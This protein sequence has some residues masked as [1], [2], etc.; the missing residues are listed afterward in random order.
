MK[1]NKMF[2][3]SVALALALFGV[4]FM[5]GKAFA[6]V[7]HGVDVALTVP[8]MCSL[9]ITNDDLS[10][11]IVPG[12]NYTIGTSNLKALC[13]DASGFAIYTVGYTG[14]TYGD[15]NLRITES[16]RSEYIPSSTTA[17]SKWNM[18]VANN[19]SVSGNYTATISDGTNG[20]ENFTT[21]HIVPTTYKMIASRTAS[22][23]QT[24]G[25][26]INTTFAVNVSYAQRPGT[27]QGIVKF[28]LVHPVSATPPSS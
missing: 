21:S 5:S 24:V 10:I 9:T 16:G 23:D 18:T 8:M 20:T 22:T 3:G 27:Y 28:V 15:N 2:R 11:N 17:D 26:N 19:T 7:S 12:R 1:V 25:A 6:E 14:E 4:V 13:N